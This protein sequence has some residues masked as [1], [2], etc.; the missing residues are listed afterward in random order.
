MS[1]AA[2][3]IE[4]ATPCTMAWETMSGSARVRFC[5]ACAKQV[6][7][8]SALTEA[9]AAAV[10]ALPTTACVAYLPAPD[11]SVQYA[12]PGF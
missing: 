12:A 6:H 5:T 2:R 7:T 11:G 9:E 4:L 3:T 10:L 1:P 8:L